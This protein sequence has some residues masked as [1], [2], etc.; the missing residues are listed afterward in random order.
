MTRLDP[1]PQPPEFRARAFA[2]PSESYVSGFISP[3][4]DGWQV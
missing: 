2:N 4:Q 3:R 1:G